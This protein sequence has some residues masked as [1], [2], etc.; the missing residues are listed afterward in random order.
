[1]ENKSCNFPISPQA[2]TSFVLHEFIFSF[3]LYF[4]FSS[5]TILIFCE[6]RALHNLH[7]QQPLTGAI[8]AI[9]KTL[10]P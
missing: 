10:L 2:E 7:N 4:Y 6:S 1:M 9:D 5:A 8:T 3:H